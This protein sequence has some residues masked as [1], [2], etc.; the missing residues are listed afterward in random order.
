MWCGYACPQTVF[1]DRLYR[2]IERWVEGSPARSRKLDQA[3]WGVKKISKRSLKWFL[4]LIVSL[5]I[6]HSGMGFFVGTHELLHISVQSP[7]NNL[8]LFIT[9]LVLTG[10][11]LFD[12]GWF[13]D[14]FCIIACPYGRFQSIVMDEA[15]LIVGYDEKRGEPRKRTPGVATE[16]LGDCVNCDQCVKACPTGIDIR[17]GL[18]MECLACTACI[19]ACD[20][21][22]D[23]VKKP[24][25][26]IR[27][28]SEAEL[29]NEKKTISK[30]IYIYAAILSLILAGLVYQLEVRGRVKVQLIR[31]QGE[32]FSIVK[33]ELGKDL[34]LNHYILKI[35]NYEHSTNKLEVRLAQSQLKND[36]EII[37]PGD[38]LLINRD[39]NTVSIFF[40]FNSRVL[41]NG[42]TK[43]TVNFI[44]YDN[45]NVLLTKEVTLVGPIR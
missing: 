28:T 38:Y 9:M 12:F 21:I 27:Y 4:Y 40:R 14:Q 11:V 7:L 34:I 44:D 42:A 10:I 43:V 25:G 20:E 41:E 16:D 37:S 18:Q 39:N 1:I 13:R 3:V 45:K 5:H 8:P 33:N 32:T 6:V 23:R 2:V 29:K 22:M 30:R 36:I 35:N 31:G 26:L 15:S 19:D 24:K 17:D